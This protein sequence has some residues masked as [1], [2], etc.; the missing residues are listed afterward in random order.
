[1]IHLEPLDRQSKLFQAIYESAM[2]THSD[3][4]NS[5]SVSIRNIYRADKPSERLSYLPFE[6]TLHNKFLLWHGCRLTSVMANLREGLRMPS[7]ESAATGLMFGKGIY[8]TD[9]FSKAA[10]L[11]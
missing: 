1:M 10:N 7:R 4:H 3:Q 11:A 8:F 9:C 6:K 2:N 5:F